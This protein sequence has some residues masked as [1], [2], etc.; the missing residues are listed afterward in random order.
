MFIG[1]AVN[2]YLRLQTSGE[3]NPSDLI[4]NKSFYSNYGGGKY[5]PEPKQDYPQNNRGDSVKIE[6]PSDNHSKININ[7]ASIEEL[8]SIK[9][10]G[11]VLAERIDEYRRVN[12]KFKGADDLL[13]VRGIGPKNVQKFLPFIDFNE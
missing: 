2:L 1:T 3:L 12:G 8:I 4:K 10:I 11:P 7:S 13:K 9:G 5:I 6:L